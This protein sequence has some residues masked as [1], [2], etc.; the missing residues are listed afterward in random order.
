MLTWKDTTS[1]SQHARNRTPGEWQTQASWIRIT[2][3]RHIHYAPDAWLLST[4]P[5]L[6]E[7]WEL[8]SKSADGAKL[9]AE[10]MVRERL[11]LAVNALRT[12]HGAGGGGEEK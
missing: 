12:D 3:H 5:A 8:V 9:E 6:F 1:Y 4:V 11:E 2:V 7:R 10:M